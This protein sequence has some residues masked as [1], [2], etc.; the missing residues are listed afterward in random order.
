MFALRADPDEAQD[1]F[2]ERRSERPDWPDILRELVRM[3][4]QSR[5]SGGP[6]AEA[7][8]RLQELGY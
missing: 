8:L 6:A 4:V 1:V 3:A 2:A 5:S 7:R